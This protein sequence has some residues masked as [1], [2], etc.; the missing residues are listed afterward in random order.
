[1]YIPDGFQ[2]SLPLSMSFSLP[3]DRPLRALAQPMANLLNLPHLPDHFPLLVYAFILFTSVHLVISPYLSARIFPISYGKLRSKRAINQWNIQVVSLFHVFIVLPLALA[4]L[5]SDTL[6]ADKLWGWDDRVGRTVAVACGYF[7]WDTLDAIF[8]FDDLGFL[9]HGVSCFTLYMMTFR[10]FLGYYAPRFLTW[11]LST[12]FLN[13]HRFLDKTGHTGSSAQ[14]LN[15]VVL[16][17]TFF[18]V[19]IVY[20]WY[21][22]LDFMHSLYAARAEL[23]TIYLLAFALGNLTLNGLNLTW[24]YKMIF[25]IRKRFD[26]ESKP[27]T[28]AANGI[29]VPAD[30]SAH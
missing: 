10:P 25:A 18:S 30:A 29:A 21:L 16:L 20:G 4:C 27:L 3:T 22:T 26:G 23:P 5:G 6:K 2:G 19:R 17:S 11:E 7:L 12:I 8:N 1:M 15:G 14:W 28:G 24:F 9:I 13:I